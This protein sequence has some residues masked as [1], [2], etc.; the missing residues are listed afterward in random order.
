MQRI[1]F[2]DFDI[3]RLYLI[4]ISPVKCIIYNMLKPII[5]L[6]EYSFLL[7]LFCQTFNQFAFRANIQTPNANSTNV[8][9][10]FLSLF[11]SFIQFIATFARYTC[12]NWAEEC[13][14]SMFCRQKRIHFVQ[15]LAWIIIRHAFP[16]LF[17]CICFGH[18]Q[19]A[20]RPFLMH[21]LDWLVVDGSKFEVNDL[22]IY[23]PCDR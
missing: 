19:F 13:V 17:P 7:R 10:L 14:L 2:L 11:N 15:Q 1:E 16:C 21:H 20:E 8:V 3:F 9:L 5:V 22:V 4:C 18:T 12:E 23:I 6:F